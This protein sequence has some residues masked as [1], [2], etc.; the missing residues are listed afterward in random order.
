[1]TTRKERAASRR[2][3]QKIAIP[4]Y[5]A[6]GLLVLIAVLFLLSKNHSNTTVG[7]A[8]VGEP[9][10]NFSLT[11]PTEK[12]STSVITPVKRCW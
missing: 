6:G 11:E 12:P 1:M 3:Q 7:P 9:L 10:G 4:V 8:Q 5:V 2:Q